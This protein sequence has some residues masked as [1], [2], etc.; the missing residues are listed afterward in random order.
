MMDINHTQW[1]NQRAET[2]KLIWQQLTGQFF[3]RRSEFFKIHW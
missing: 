3:M 2:F 1:F